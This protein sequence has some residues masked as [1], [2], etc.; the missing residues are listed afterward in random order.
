MFR[1]T[2]QNHLLVS[3]KDARE[4]VTDYTSDSLGVVKTVTLPSITV[5]G[6]PTRPVTTV[7]NG[8]TNAA[9]DW[10][11]GVGTAG[12]P[13]PRVD[14]DTLRVLVT[15]ARGFTTKFQLDRFGA[16]LRIEEPLGRTTVIARDEH[17]RPDTVT[18]PS[19]H[20]TSITYDPIRAS[21][22]VIQTRDET[23]GRTVNISYGS[24]RFDLPERIY[25]DV[26]ERTFVYKDT[27]EGRW[28]L[29]STWV[30]GKKAAHYTFD[31]RGRLT[32]V[33]DP[34]GHPTGYAY[35][36]QGWQNTQFVTEGLR[37]LTAYVPNSYGLTTSIT[38]PDG[39]T[40]QTEFDVVNRV[41]R[42]VDPQSEATAYNY[43]DPLFLTSVTDAKQQTY[44]FQRNAL[45]W[46]EVET[47]PRALQMRYGCDVDGNLT[48]STNRRQQTVTW[49][50]DDLDRVASRTADGVTTTYGTDPADHWT[51]ASNAQS[52]DT[53]YFDNAERVE[54]VVTIR[55]N[56]RHAIV[57]TS[58]SRDRLTSLTSTNWS[59]AYRYDA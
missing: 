37:R 27:A 5:N 39:Q 28:V 25:G 49:T 40:S 24:N 20:K 54:S 14:P 41:R 56:G 42:T 1:G 46:V 8:L 32:D 57:H 16:P 38:A 17:S 23:T 44:Q 59:V 45:G 53:T 21:S 58:D 11:G 50:Y 36:P 4:S 33:T 26:A 55:P 31:S 43:D 12:N 2:Y 47:D 13:R 9:S 10:A 48:S 34:E 19:G 3:R 29:D 6:S 15:N 35:D 52:T 7:V 22:R 51:M 18:E 30:T